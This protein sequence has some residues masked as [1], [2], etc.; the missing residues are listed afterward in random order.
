LIKIAEIGQ[1]YD[2]ILSQ[3]NYIAIK[4]SFCGSQIPALT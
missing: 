3:H 1:F 4:R 2:Y